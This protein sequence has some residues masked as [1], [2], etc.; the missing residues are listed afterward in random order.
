MVNGWFIQS[1]QIDKTVP[2]H[3]PLKMQQLKTLASD[4]IIKRNH[5]KTIHLLIYYVKLH[6]LHPLISALSLVTW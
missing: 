1:K 3:D 4:G 6:T 5:V 2:Y